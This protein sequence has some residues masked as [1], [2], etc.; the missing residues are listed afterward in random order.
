MDYRQFTDNADHTDVDTFLVRRAR[1][2]IE[3]TMA[4]YYEFRLLPDFGGTA[5]TITDAYMNVHYCDDFQLEAG[6]FKQPFS[7]EQ[8]I[9]DRY[10]PAMER[11]MIDQMVPARD[12]GVMLWGY[13]LFDNRLDYGVALSNGEINGNTDLNNNK[14]L[15]GRLA[16]RPLFNADG[17]SP[18]DH[19]QVGISAG[20]G[21]ESEPVGPSVF[22]RC[23]PP[24]PGSP[25]TRRS[26][27]PAL[28]TRL[29]PEIAWFYGPLGFA[30]Q[31][32]EE[33]QQLR[34]SGASAITNTVITDGYYVMG[35]CFLTGEQRTEYS[36][37]IEPLRPINPHCFCCS[38]GAW[39]VLFRV[40]RLDVSSS[41]F[42]AGA[43]NMANATNSSPGATETTLGLN[44]YWNKWA[45]MQLNW[46]HAWFDTPVALGGPANPYLSF[47]DTLYTRM[48]FIF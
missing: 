19:L 18:L 34:P 14:D 24:C 9:Q 10:V 43:A 13:K 37:Q 27:P 45:R 12:E 8:L 23:R 6:K 39:E 42:A 35:T 31:Y 32:Y 40:S 29:S 47:Q 38:E 44:W 33:Q 41:V 7:Y 36:Q 30:A 11:S 17:L 20:V 21:V 28:R 22:A 25:T 2:G 1:L 4:E 16:V 26:W 5:P 46:E 48:Q 3:A 15:N